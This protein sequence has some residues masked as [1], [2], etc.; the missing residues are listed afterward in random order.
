MAAPGVFRKVISFPRSLLH[1]AVDR[2]VV[3][4]TEPTKPFS[5][6][7]VTNLRRLKRRLRKGD[8]LLICG[9]A[10]ISYVVKVLTLSPW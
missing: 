4:L 5:P 2:A 8:V 9:N 3:H 10:R 1:R 7:E 6:S